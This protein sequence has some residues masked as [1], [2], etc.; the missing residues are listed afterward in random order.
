LLNIV[1]SIVFIK[2]YG[3]PGVLLGS[4]ISY[5]YRT[6][7]IIYYSSN[8]ILKQ[9]II[10][11]MIMLFFLVFFILGNYFVVESLKMPFFINDFFKW[12]L[13]STFVAVLSALL[14]LLFYKIMRLMSDKIY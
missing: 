13:Y 8:K 1:F 4:I 2:I 6:I 14:W 3:L 9:S 7:D 10:F 11:K 5:S 12:I